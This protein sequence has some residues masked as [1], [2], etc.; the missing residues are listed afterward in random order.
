V[1]KDAS[2][3][4]FSAKKSNDVDLPKKFSLKS[5]QAPRFAQN[6]RLQ[7]SKTFMEEKA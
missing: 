3:N 5:I 1:Q 2:L 6:P 4:I 7:D